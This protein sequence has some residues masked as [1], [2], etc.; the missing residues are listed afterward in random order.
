MSQGVSGCL[1]VSQEVMKY[2][3]VT[4]T[5]PVGYYRIPVQLQVD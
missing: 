4:C 3:K 1:R 5:S 2:V